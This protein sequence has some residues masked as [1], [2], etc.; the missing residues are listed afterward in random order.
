MTLRDAAVGSGGERG[1]GCR[2]PGLAAACAPPLPRPQVSPVPPERAPR[3][4]PA[5]PGSL[6]SRRRFRAR[7]LRS[8]GLLFPGLVCAGRAG[9]AASGIFGRGRR[10]PRESTGVNR[11]VEEGLS[12]VPAGGGR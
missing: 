3:F 8:G 5:R 2:G 12:S 7:L 10:P 11:A 4:C 9:R 6:P 1:G